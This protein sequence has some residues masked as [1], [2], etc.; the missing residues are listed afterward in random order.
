MRIVVITAVALVAGLGLARPL[1]AFAAQPD[2]TYWY[3]DTAKQYW[4][5][6]EDVFAFR[7]VDRDAFS[8]WIDTTVVAEHYFRAEKADRLN[9]VCFKAGSTGLQRDF[10]RHHIQ[11]SGQYGCA[12][13]V[14]TRQP[15]AVYGQ[16]HWHIAGD[17]VL[18]V[19]ENGHIPALALL[20][21]MDRYHLIFDHAPGNGLPS[22]GAY[23][24]IFTVDDSILDYQDA[25]AIAA[26]MIETDDQLVKSAEPE[27]LDQFHPIGSPGGGPGA[28]TGMDDPAR[29]EMLADHLVHY[30]F[31]ESV[32]F[33]Y[34]LRQPGQRTQV[35]IFD[36]VGRE[37][38]GQPL[39]PGN[40]VHKVL[41]NNFPKG[42][43]F[44]NVA[45]VQGQLLF[46]YK[47]YK[48]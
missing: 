30:N 16:G 12:F 17:R 29:A 5:F 47:F 36:A 43:Y 24:Y 21:F 4:Y 48:F 34:E 20:D 27:L 7:T 11:T 14:I 33:R 28:A 3:S 39:P 23:T 8:G 40:T 1:A 19:F 22:G 32:L 31:N 10:V 38:Y 15:Q 35:A 2:S 18:V 37:I 6:Q 46:N 25:I 45:T 44:L 26:S 42:I 9:V 41:V 13:P